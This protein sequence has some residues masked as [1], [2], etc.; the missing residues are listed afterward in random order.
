MLQ[1]SVSALREL[2][3]E[4]ASGL[5]ARD[6]EIDEWE[7]RI[8]LECLRILALYDPT[9]SDLRRMVVILK[10]NEELER[11]ADSVVRLAKRVK[12]LARVTDAASIP[13]PLLDLAAN[14]E[15]A[16][17]RALDA[18]TNIDVDAALSVVAGDAAID[19]QCHT[20]QKQFKQALRDAPEGSGVSLRLLLLARNLERI[21]DHATLIARNVVYLKEGRIIRHAAGRQAGN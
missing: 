6:R 4:L 10:S 8:E 2:R 14:A 18:L 3:P 5:K 11:V 7:V 21:A 19:H 16:F 15:A 20:L 9:A 13:S 1:A 17:R 12:K